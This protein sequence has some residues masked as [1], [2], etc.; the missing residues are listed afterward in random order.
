MPDS[1]EVKLILIG[2]TIIILGL[3]GL[4]IIALLISQKRKFRHRQTLTDLKNTYDK[5]ILKTQLE[6]QSQTFETV[7]RELHDN[8]GTLISIAMVHIDS[9]N[10]EGNNGQQEKIKESH[11]L[12][13]E[14]M[15]TLKDISKSINPEKL[16]SIGIVKAIDQ[17]LEKHRKANRFKIEYAVQG[18]EFKIEPQRLIVLFRI[19]QE[20]L[21]NII[22]HADA[23]E[24]NVKLDF[25]SP[26]LGISIA[27]NGKGF[28]VAN[29]SS[30][31]GIKNMASRAKLIGADLEI[32]SDQQ[33]GTII[34]IHYQESV[35]AINEP[36]L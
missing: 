17:E 19:A 13:D 22:K 27:D 15:D 18:N 20:A 34:L 5:E 11:K 6:I 36:R 24:V 26:S 4:I 23:K 12:L 33:K 7:S 10:G 3:A 16:S 28:Q 35:P 25:S 14:A 8:V 31:S 1:I 9:L 30:G 32:I 29:D 21:N 2:S